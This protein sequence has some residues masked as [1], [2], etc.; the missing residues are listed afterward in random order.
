MLCCSAQSFP[1]V[2]R[3]AFPG[4][5]LASGFIPGTCPGLG[6]LPT[7]TACLWRLANAEYRVQRLALSPSWER[8]WRLWPLE[9][10]LRSW[11]KL[12]SEPHWLLPLPIQLACFP[13]SHSVDPDVRSS[14]IFCGTQGGENMSPLLKKKNPLKVLKY[15]AFTF[16][17]LIISL[18]STC[19]SF[20]F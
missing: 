16:F 18:N 13:F 11:P 10:A 19:L 8:P 4:S 9:G 17:F 5:W 20:L 12:L 6:E 2:L 7:Q 3:H 15:K 1:A 14:Y